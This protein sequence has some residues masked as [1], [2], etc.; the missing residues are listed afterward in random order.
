MDFGVQCQGT[1]METTDQI[2]LNATCMPC[3]LRMLPC[4]HSDCLAFSRQVL[5]IQRTLEWLSLA[6]R[7]VGEFYVAKLQINPGLVR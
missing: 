5:H 7:T 3:I 2:S 1:V 4:E 6:P